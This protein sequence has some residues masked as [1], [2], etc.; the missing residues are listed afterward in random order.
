MRFE[1]AT[2]TDDLVRERWLAMPMGRR[3]EVAA[4]LMVANREFARAG[5]R[6]RHPEYT[7]DEVRL[8]EA[9]ARLGGSMFAAAFPAAAQLDP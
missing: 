8:S 1:D 5:I 2:A 7:D 3:A 9:R 4:D 6:I